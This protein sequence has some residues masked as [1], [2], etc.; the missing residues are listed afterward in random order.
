M[1]NSATE[2]TESTE[3][4]IGLDAP[5]IRNFF[6][7]SGPSVPPP[8]AEFRYANLHPLQNPNFVQEMNVLGFRAQTKMRTMLGSLSGKASDNLIKNLTQIA[9]EMGDIVGQSPTGIANLSETD[10]AKVLVLMR[11]LYRIY[12]TILE[13]K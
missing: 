7:A 5:N 3:L 1:S 13:A 2:N 10:S 12:K 9:T 4:K 6:E 11:S 8:V